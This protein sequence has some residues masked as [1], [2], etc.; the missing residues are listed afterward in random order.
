ISVS[1]P[2]PRLH[3]NHKQSTENSHDAETMSKCMNI[4][5]FIQISAEFSIGKSR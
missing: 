4:R 1:P 3:R 5:F 2:R